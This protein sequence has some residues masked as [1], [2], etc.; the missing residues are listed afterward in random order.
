MKRGYAR[1]ST[2]EQNPDLQVNALRE[3]ECDVVYIDEGVSGSTT[4]RAELNRMLD[5]LEDGEHVVVWK[6]DRLSR[7]IIDG[8]NTLAAWCDRGIRIVDCKCIAFEKPFS[9]C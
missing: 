3:A 4:E 6:L 1:V 5:D 9:R 2:N 8:I 7:T